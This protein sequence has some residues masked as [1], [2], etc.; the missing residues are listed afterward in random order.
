MNVEECQQKSV[1]KI[2]FY[3][4][5]MPTLNIF[6]VLVLEVFEKQHVPNIVLGEDWV[7]SLAETRDCI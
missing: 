5:N 6:H 1:V 7:I 2:N 4:L 3:I